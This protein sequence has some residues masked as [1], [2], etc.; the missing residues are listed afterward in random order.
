MTTNTELDNEGA[1]AELF[2]IFNILGKRHLINLRVE[3]ITAEGALSL[4]AHL[5]QNLPAG[6]LA[7]LALY[8]GRQMLQKVDDP[9]LQQFRSMMLEEVERAV[10]NPGSVVEVSLTCPTGFFLLGDYARLTWSTHQGSL[11]LGRNEQWREY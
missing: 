4:R 5:T 7:R 10:A 6:N 1:L 11:V 2:G 9:D 3:L 8:E